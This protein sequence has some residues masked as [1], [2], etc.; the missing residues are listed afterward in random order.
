MQRGHD[1]ALRGHVALEV[2]A[3]NVGKA[4]AR[5]GDGALGGGPAANGGH[6]GGGAQEQQAG[7]ADSS[8]RRRVIPRGCSITLSMEEAPGIM[9]QA[10]NP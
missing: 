5:A 9:A 7:G 8:A 2:A 10:D 3:D 1:A 6:G 4:Q